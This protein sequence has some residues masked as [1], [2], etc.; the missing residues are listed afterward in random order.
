MNLNIGIIVVLAV[1]G[2]WVLGVFLGIIGGI[3]KPFSSRSPAAVDSSVVQAQEQKTIE[4]TE[5]KRKQL[6]DNMKQKMQDLSQQ[7]SRSF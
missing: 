5:A 2:I 3:S 7:S 4:D 1:A 6:M